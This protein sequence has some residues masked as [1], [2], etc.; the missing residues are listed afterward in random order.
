MGTRNLTM[1]ISDGKTRIAQY[2]QWDGYPDGQGVNALD[3]LLTAD[4]K[5]FKKQLKRCAFIDDKKEKEIKKFQKELGCPEGYMTQKQAK[6]F[7]NEYPY[8]SRDTGA[9]ILEM[10]Y[11]AKGKNN[12]W[13]YD[14]TEFA[15]DSLFCEWA[16]VIDFDKNVFEVYKGFNKKP[17]TK[18]DRFYNKEKKKDDYSPVKLIKSYSLDTLPT[19]TQFVDYFKRKDE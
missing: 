11:H 6:L 18:K 8:I 5:K 16:Y 7:Y 15:Y 12:I 10:I 9:K 2:G 19:L 4:L 14:S 1:V 17:N 3:F 13:L